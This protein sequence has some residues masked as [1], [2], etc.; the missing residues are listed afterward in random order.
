MVQS[1]HQKQEQGHGAPL[2]AAVYGAAAWKIMDYLPPLAD[3]YVIHAST[4]LASGVVLACAV[5]LATYT[6]DKAATTLDW[7]AAKLPKGN[8]GKAKWASWRALRKDVK[9]YGWAPYWGTYAHGIIHRGKVIMADYESNAMTV[10]PAGSGKGVAVVQPSAMAIRHSKFFM[11]LKGNYDAIL[12]QPLTARGEAFHTLNL[13]GLSHIED[14]SCYN[15]SD[16]LHDDFMRD[17]GLADVFSDAE[18]FA[19]KLY[20]ESN[21]GMDSFWPIG[22]Q[23][24]IA[25]ALV[26]SS[27]VHGKDSNFFLAN[28]MLLDRK[29]FL[30]D[31]QWVS[32]QLQ[33]ADGHSL[34]SMPL[35]QSPLLARHS[36]EDRK[37]FIQFYRAK[38]ASV[39]DLL[40]SKDNK[41]AESFITGARQAMRA[42]RVDSP[43]HKVL[44]KSSFR[45]HEMK[46]SDA[47]VNVA[48]A[49]DSTRLASQQPIA[50]LL[51]CCAL[52]ELRRSKGK[53][54]VYVFA[55]ECTTF[56]IHDLAKL[57]TYGREYR[58]RLHLIFQSIAAFRTA[59]GQDALG[60]LLSETEI[61]QF[62]AGIREPE[63]LDMI[64]KMLG[65]QSIIIKS[66]NGQM[67]EFGIKGY[68]YAE[69]GKKQLSFDEIRR[70][71]K[72]IL[73]IRGNNAVLTDNPFIAAIHPWR[74]QIGNN[75]YFDK[76]F[77][78]PIKLR[79]GN[80][81]PPLVLR[82]FYHMAGGW[83]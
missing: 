3:S 45:F 31:M 44:S 27:L 1:V 48:I 11:D 2:S 46:E 17:G 82:P 23:D 72:G 40:A 12:R 37:H 81:K 61:K 68:G 53:N 25:V 42:F 49:V 64:E 62:L 74:K 39:A 29:A 65:N 56:K 63:L 80:R 9:Q 24:L 22:S 43:A 10:A 16:I 8:K 60:T 83:P 5:T 51:Q 73:F 7:Y 6:L 18:E 14:Q 59:Y 78:Q 54:P 52:I 77:L 76:P 35:E 15:P 26:Q 28:Q 21:N 58:I 13:G 20:P 19:A 55:D 32:G 4:A 36:K 30:H 50:S 79:I 33:D 70:L 69:D 38:A 75:P 71:D 67:E 34:P 66:H 57:L 47:P 41:T